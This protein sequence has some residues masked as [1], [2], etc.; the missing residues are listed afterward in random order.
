MLATVAESADDEA[1]D[2]V[3]DGI[4]AVAPDLGIDVETLSGRAAEELLA[5]ARRLD[6]QL[7]VVGSRGRGPIRAA[8]LGSVSSKLVQETDRPIM[9][10]SRGSTAER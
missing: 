2:A 6:A 7:V 10:V 4:R 3:A 5:L 8:V 9:I 1:L